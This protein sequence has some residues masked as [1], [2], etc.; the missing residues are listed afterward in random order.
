MTRDEHLRAIYVVGSEKVGK[1][2]VLVM[3]CSGPDCAGAQM[4]SRLTVADVLAEA[5]AHVDKMAD[6]GAQS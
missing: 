5:S 2:S 4:F 3:L 6:L 1:V